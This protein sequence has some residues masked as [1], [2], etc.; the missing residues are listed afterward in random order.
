M[1]L[2]TFTRHIREGVK[3]IFRNGWMTFASVS[4]VTVTLLLVGSF[5]AIMMNL[6]QFAKTIESD[7]KISV[8]IALEA[9]ESDVAGLEANIKRIPEVESVTFS[10]KDDQ[11]QKLIDSMGEEGESFT[12]FEQDNPLNDVFIV[13]TKEPTDVIKV[14]TQI[15]RYNQADKV[16]YG[17][18]TVEKLFQG[19]G[20]ARNIGI[21]IIVGLLFT[22][23]FL[24]S[25]TIKITIIARRKEIEIMKLVGATNGFIRWPFFIEGLLLG[26]IGSILPIVLTVSSYHY[27]FTTA[28]PKLEDTFFQLLPVTPFVFQLSG[29]LLLIGAFI[30]VWGSLLSVRKF[31]KV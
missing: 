30:G 1:N 31:L 9:T 15:E 11:L 20:I 25:N 24:I 14:A 3:N 18:G 10:S 19:I 5:L 17:K 27:L 21:G 6:N 16:L 4:A 29:I 2:R 22:A 13:T 28:N 23:M 12:L 7:V 8:H 26:V